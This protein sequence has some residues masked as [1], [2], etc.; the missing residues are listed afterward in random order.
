[1]WDEF[2]EDVKDEEFANRDEYEMWV[3]AWVED[4]INEA[5]RIGRFALGLNDKEIEDELDVKIGDKDE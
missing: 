4:T 3:D 1:M 2:Y 5:N